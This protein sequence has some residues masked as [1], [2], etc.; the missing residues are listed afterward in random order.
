MSEI[1]SIPTLQEAENPQN[2]PKI[3][4][5][6]AD[7]QAGLAAKILGSAKA[8]F[9]RTMAKVQ[10]GRGRPKNCP[11]CGNPETKCICPGG[12]P[13]IQA[14]PISGP[15]G[16]QAID[17]EIITEAVGAIIK[18]ATGTADFFLLE[19]ARQKSDDRE[20]IES[21]LAR[22]Q[23]TEGELEALGKLSAICLKKYG[24]GTEYCPEIGLAAIL[25]GIGCRYAV[26]FRSIASMPS[27]IKV[28]A[29]VKP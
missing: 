5:N 23:P 4:S 16:G 29:E 12:S 9:G 24:V 1:P 25:T 20:W 26:A 8:A 2:E 28:K 14:G 15:A 22:C 10:R 18:T 19:K 7:S 17:D 11:G 6:P 3:E 27:P 13:Q 21:T